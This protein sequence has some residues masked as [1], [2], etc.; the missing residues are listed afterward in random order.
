MSKIETLIVCLTKTGHPKTVDCG[1]KTTLTKQCFKKNTPKTT[2]APPHFSTKPPFFRASKSLV[3]RWWKSPSKRIS[4]DSQ[5]SFSW[6][7]KHFM[8]QLCPE[9]SAFSAMKE[10]WLEPPTGSKLHPFLGWGV[11]FT[12]NPQVSLKW[13]LRLIFTYFPRRTEHGTWK[14]TSG[15]SPPN[16]Q[17]PSSNFFL[18]GGFNIFFFGDEKK[19]RSSTRISHPKVVSP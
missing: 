17:H 14:K 2:K 1:R 18:W 13:N 10:S 19:Q 5:L 6:G 4:S 12:T 3:F 11:F 16:L 8:P 9:I 7:Q 15:N